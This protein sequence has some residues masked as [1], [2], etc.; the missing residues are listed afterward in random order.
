MNRTLITDFEA[1]NLAI[2]V[3]GRPMLDQLNRLT[4][5]IKAQIRHYIK[6]G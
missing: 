4:D 1:F 6:N 5:P 2:E 3:D